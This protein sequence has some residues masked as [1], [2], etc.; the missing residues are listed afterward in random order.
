MPA[1]QRH[2][3][4]TAT[5]PLGQ[6]ALLFHRMTG[7]EALSRLYKYKIEFLSEINNIAFEDILG[8]N[9]CINLRMADEQWRYF[10]GFVSRFKQQGMLGEY[11]C[12]RATIRPWLWFL[13][14]TTN[15]RIFQAMTVPDIV[16]QVCNDNG[17][18]DI[19]EQLTGSYR[20]WV[21]RVQYRETDFN[22]VSRLLEHEGIYYYF[23]H[24]KIKQTLV[25]C[26]SIS[27]HESIGEIP[28]YPEGNVELRATE[29]IY[30]LSLRQQVQPGTYSQN[31]YDFEKPKANLF[32]KATVQ[33][34]HAYCDF[35]Q[36]DYPG[37]YIT[38]SEGDNYANC[39]IEELH[40]Q[41]E[42][43]KGSSNVRVCR[44]GSL[45]NLT[46][47]PRED[48]NREYLVI[49]TSYRLQSDEYFSTNGSQDGEDYR[50]TFHAVDSK[51][52][53]RA[54]RTTLKPVVEGPQTAVVVGPAGEEIYTDEY[55][56][57]K[58]HFHWDREGK[59]DENST[60]WIRVSQVHAGKGFG[61]IDIP[62]IG[63]EVIVDFLEGDPD[64]PI[65]IGRVY[66]NYTMPAY[67][68][69][70]NK[71]ISGL[72]SNATKGGSGFNEIRFDDKKG[73]EQIFFHA[74]K[75]QDIRV[76]NDHF[77]FIGNDR[78][79]IIKCDQLEK[80]EGDKHLTVTGDKNDKINGTVSRSIDMDLQEKIGNRHGL[81]AGSEIHLKAGMNVII[82]ADSS[83]T[84]KAGDEFIV[85]SPAGVT[86][87]DKQ[88]L[89]NSGGSPG[90][91]AGCVPDVAK[92]P[93]EADN[94]IPV[95]ISKMPPP[96]TS[97]KKVPTRHFTNRQ[98]QI[99]AKAAEN[100]T[101]FCE[102]CEAAKKAEVF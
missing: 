92:H 57:V 37:Q 52:P 41:F 30:K 86:I 33:R 102:K 10:N 56:R 73:E 3:P 4:I 19:E 22:F 6:D 84:L 77:E 85:V 96:I 50:C 88:G 29:H 51:Q 9:I 38:T 54:Q 49:S 98:A 76:K 62:R 70:A 34:N 91:G 99:L 11:Y 15:C 47:Y 97:I 20:T 78:H 17:F 58:V 69:P 1:I 24:E 39:R 83:I 75:N 79:L 13:T 61:G 5:T 42:Q 14:R 40:S 35:E 64:R 46:H 12:Y 87:S 63:E 95:E 93:V 82:E 43:I 68:L 71:S 27:A 16:K 32:V 21:Y 7:K 80:V 72:R 45:F 90:S 28:Y 18:T 25:L 94:A 55:G 100:G 59:M 36:Y 44:S 48:Q 26:D 53:F 89:I 31:D 2:R 23:R 67:K 101:P 74:E 65:I 81:Q 66:N 60:C 8:Q